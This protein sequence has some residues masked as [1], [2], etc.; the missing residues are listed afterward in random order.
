MPAYYNVLKCSHTFNVLDARGVVSTT[1]RARAFA[2]MRK[3]SKGVAELWVKRRGELGFPL[4]AI[5]EVVAPEALPMPTVT[6]PA[7]PAVRDR[8]RGVAGR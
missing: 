4:G 6:E 1:E 8:G 2:L 7:T 3:L 5:D